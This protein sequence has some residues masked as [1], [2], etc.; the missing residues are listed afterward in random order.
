MREQRTALL[1]IDFVHILVADG[2]SQLPG[3]AVAAAQNAASLKEGAKKHG[4]PII[5]ANDNFGNWR[6]DFPSLVEACMR[7]RGCAGRLAELLR[8]EPDDF[9][10]LKPR[11]SAFFGTPLEFLL[12]ELAVKRLILA[13]LETDVCVMYTAQDAHMRKFG[14]WV[15][16]NCTASRSKARQAAALA[17]MRQ[18]LKADTRPSNRAVTQGAQ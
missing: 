12:D 3:A 17:F 1:L 9:T 13:G 4:I 18:N 15:P 10:L 16:R 5:Y 6:S 8:P 2:G 7:R 11:H 14:L